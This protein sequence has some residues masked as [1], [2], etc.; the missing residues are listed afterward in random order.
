MKEITSINNK[1]IKYLSK[2]KNKKNI[3]EEGYFIVEG[4]NL[5]PEAISAGIVY[6]LLVISKEMYKNFNGEKTLVNK[7]S[8]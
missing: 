5:I 4:K 1:Y 3:I 7:K 8:R 2:L 6:D